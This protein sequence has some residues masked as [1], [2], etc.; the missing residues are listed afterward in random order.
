M[1]KKLSI[2]IPNYNNE[3]YL[4]RSLDCVIEQTYKNVEIIVVNDGSKGNSDEIMKTYQEKDIRVKYV[5][6]DV[7]KGLFQARLT[8]A[9][10]AT[11]DYIAFLDADDYTSIDFYRT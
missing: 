9:S 8:G 5:K 6:H 1:E 10:V 7:N 4:K 3:K 2:I 11:G